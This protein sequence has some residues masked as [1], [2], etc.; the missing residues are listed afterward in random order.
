MTFSGCRGSLCC[1]L[2][3]LLLLLPNS[4]LAELSDK[5]KINISED[6]RPIVEKTI[7]PYVEN[8]RLYDLGDVRLLFRQIRPLITNALGAMGYFNVSV[9]RNRQ[10]DET[11]EENPLLRVQVQV[12]PQSIVKQ[13]DISFVGHIAGHSVERQA[14]RKMLLEKWGLVKGKPFNQ[15]LWDSSKAKILNQLLEQDYPA[16]SIINSQAFVDQEDNTVSLSVKYDSGPAFTFGDLKIIGLNNYPERVIYGYNTIESG[17]RYEQ[18]KLLSLMAELQNTVYFSSVDVRI[19]PD[20]EHPKNVPII[21]KVTESKRHRLGLG[22]GYSS[23]SGFRTELTYQRNNLFDRAYALV[24]G[25][26]LEQKRQSAF[27]DVFLPPTQR[28]VHDSIGLSLDQQRLLQ[29][30]VEKVSVGAIRQYDKPIADFSLG[31]NYQ[32]ERREVLGQLLGET[33]A[34]VAGASV[35]RNRVDDRLNPT[36]GYLAFLQIAMAAD[37]LASDQSF[38]RLA[39]KYKTYWSFGE[40]NLVTARFEWGTVISGQGNDIPQDF[41]FRAGG[42]NSIRGYEF[43]SLGVQD[44]GVLQGGRRLAISSLE[45]TRWVRDSIGVAVFSDVGAV[46]RTW[47]D[48]DPLLSVGFGFRYRTAAGPI[49]LDFAKGEDEG[50]VRIHFALGVTF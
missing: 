10:F 46:S 29:L 21:V 13:V 30:D 25:I 48:F 8:A 31:I 33:Q 26:R 6:L 2:L 43:L 37:A 12:G 5:V 39:G 44:Q 18:E 38:L 50:K 23:N 28:G 7:A 19:E 16:A 9:R 41:L 40:K 36:E 22:A 35:K 34:L 20:R 47:S 42:T 49:A 24:S 14:Y 17:D 11:I 32:L 4:A 15:S 3:T 45:Y 27:S 1:I